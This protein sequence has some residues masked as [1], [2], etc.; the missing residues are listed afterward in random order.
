VVLVK[1]FKFNVADVSPVDQT[2]EP[3]AGVPVAVN[4]VDWPEHNETAGRFK[5]KVGPGFTV[6][7]AVCNEL[8]Q[9][10]NEYVTE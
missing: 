2:Y 10:F 3:P 7:F 4:V 9:P 6:T 8:G 1:L 5:L